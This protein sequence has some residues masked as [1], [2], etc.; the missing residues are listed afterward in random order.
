MLIKLITGLNMSWPMFDFI[1][2]DWLITGLNMS[3][4]MFEFTASDCMPTTENKVL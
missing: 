2:S 1:A 4:P 3:W